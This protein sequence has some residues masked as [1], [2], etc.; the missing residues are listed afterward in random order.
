M[1]PVNMYCGK[2]GALV[3]KDIHWRG[4]EA[5]QRFMAPLYDDMGEITD[6]YE[7]TRCPDC[8]QKLEDGALIS[9]PRVYDE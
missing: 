6:L 9:E 4:D 1:N 2:C 8:N 3:V 7:V 5:V